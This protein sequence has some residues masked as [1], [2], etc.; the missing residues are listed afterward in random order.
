MLKRKRKTFIV[1]DLHFGHPNICRYCNRP[2]EMQAPNKNPGNI[3]LLKQ[4]EEDI[5]Q[6]FDMLP[7]ECDVWNLGDLFFYQGNPKNAPFEEYRRI[8]DRMNGPRKRRRLYLVLG[9]HDEFQT[10]VYRELGFDEVYNTP[11]IVENKWVLSHEPVYLGLNTPFI[12]LYGHT[13]DKSIEDDYFMFDYENYAKEVRE[14]NAKG[15]EAPELVKKWPYK[16]VNTSL[17]YRNCCLDYNRCIL[18]WSTDTLT[19][20]NAHPTGWTQL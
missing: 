3:P 17:N 2:Y 12:N 5:L 9:N 18:D 11:V 7:E 4:M 13:H 19:L 14:A 8:V 15:L 16:E 10:S 1:S 6:M 20:T